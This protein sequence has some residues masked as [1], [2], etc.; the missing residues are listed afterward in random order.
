MRLAIFDID[1][2]LTNTNDIDLRNY[3]RALADEFG[4]AAPD[5]N[6]SDY[7]HVTD[8]GITIDV[9][10]QHLGRA[11]TTAEV[12]QLRARLVALFDA[13]LAAT[14]GLVTAVPGAQHLLDHLRT[15][16]EWAI[17]LATGCWQAS[18]RWKLQAAGLNV[19][20]IPAAFCEDGI[21]REEIVT[22][23]LRRT[24]EAAGHDDF[25]SKVSV[26]DGEWDVR[27]AANLDL[28]FLGIRTAGDKAFLYR[29]GAKQVLIDYADFDGALRALAQAEPPAL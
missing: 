16:R 24:T 28:A 1:G 18:A 13:E 5:L 11:P 3:I 7:P 29:H 26:G 19:D 4:I 23:A 12:E 10:I 2:T 6:W 25:E 8:I 27:T 17:G 15:S 14:P 9:F 21:S 22:A 20:G